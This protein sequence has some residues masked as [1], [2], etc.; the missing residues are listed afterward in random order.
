V[1]LKNDNQSL[2]LNKDEVIFLTG[3]A[4]DN[5]GYMSGGWTTYWQGNTARDIGVGTSIKDAFSLVTSSNG[6]SLTT[7][8]NNASTVVVVLS[9]IPYSEGLGDNDTLT[10][11]SHT[12]DSGNFAALEIAR[13]AHEDGKNVVGILISGRPL[14]LEGYLE[15]FDSFVAAWLPGSEGGLGIADV[16]FGDN[17]FTGKL[18]YTWPKTIEQVGYTSVREDYDEDYVLFPYGYGL[19]YID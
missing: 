16:V 2:P 6:G 15:Y 10:L 4:S 19:S 9:E 7:N 8:L 11:T 3:E 17:D 13:Q 14:L 18:S 5:I 12:A 1:L